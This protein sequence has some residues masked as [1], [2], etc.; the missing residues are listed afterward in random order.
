MNDPNTYIIPT[1]DIIKNNKI[2]IKPEKELD[3][4]NGH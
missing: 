3:H 4:F 1:N 2:L